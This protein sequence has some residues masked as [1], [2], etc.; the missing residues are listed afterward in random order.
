MNN[1]PIILIGYSGHGFVAYGIFKAAGMPVLGYCDRES[2]NYNPF[3]L[4]YFGKE[5]DPLV[6]KEMANYNFFISVGENSIRKKIYQFLIKKKIY[7][8]N[9]IHPAAVIDFSCL[10]RNE[11]VMI[12]ANA[13][14]NPLS[15]IEKGAICNTGSIIEHECV[16]GEFAHIGPGA[17]LCGNVTIGA[18]SF[19][20]ANSVIRQGITIGKNVIVGAGSVVVKDVADNSTVIGNPSRQ[21]N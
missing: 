2:K 6:L 9:A 21:V 18:Q 4:K 13:V 8:I 11:G 12:S 3:E 10:I 20:G 15:R 1:K 16:V 5:D 7:S 17:V 19:I 14:I